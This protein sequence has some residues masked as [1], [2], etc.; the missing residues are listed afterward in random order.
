MTLRYAAADVGLIDGYEHWRT[1]SVLV[2]GTD[3]Q[4]FWSDRRRPD[5][6]HPELMADLWGEFDGQPIDAG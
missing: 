1:T 3:R 2:S 6:E 5:G 4:G